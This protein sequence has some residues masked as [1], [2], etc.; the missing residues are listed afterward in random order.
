MSDSGDGIVK[1]ELEVVG[2]AKRWYDFFD[3]DQEDEQNPGS[4]ID[5]AEYGM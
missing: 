5:T 1:A 3:D 2:G 4:N